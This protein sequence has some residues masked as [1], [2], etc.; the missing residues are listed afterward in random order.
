MATR[1]HRSLI[2]L[3]SEIA[4]LQMQAAQAR[5]REVAD[6]VDRI[7]KAIAAYGLTATDLGF[8]AGARATPKPRQAVSQNEP[9]PR[10]AS[11]VVKGSK[12]APKYRDA[13][14]NTWTGRGLKPRWL[15]AALQAGRKLEDFAI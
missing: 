13:S 14:G 2:E 5:Q 4:A 9:K 6:V 15:A 7:K 8:R 12:I 10:R 3:Q 1:T 11:K